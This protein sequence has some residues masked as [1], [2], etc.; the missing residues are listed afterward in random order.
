MRIW[1][2]NVIEFCACHSARGV[3]LNLWQV[4]VAP[5]I[6]K[7]HHI[8]KGYAVFV[9]LSEVILP[10][11]F[12]D[13][14]LVNGERLAAFGID[15]VSALRSCRCHCYNI[16]HKQSLVKGFSEKS[17]SQ[18]VSNSL[19]TWHAAGGAPVWFCQD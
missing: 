3:R 9:R 5:L 17:Y 7:A 15:D 12:Q 2:H 11:V 4:N 18:A 8:A 6:F 10:V 16:T 19:D 1:R 13:D 14:V